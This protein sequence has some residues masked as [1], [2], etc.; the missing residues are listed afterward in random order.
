ME[1]LVVDPSDHDDEGFCED[2]GFAEEERELSLRR[3]S[4]PSGI[5]KY[6]GVRYG[7]SADVV[8][9]KGRVKVRSLPRMRKRKVQVTR[10]SE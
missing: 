6:N 1:W 9:I 4:M 2:E 8:S 7:R 10:V 3:A 5:R